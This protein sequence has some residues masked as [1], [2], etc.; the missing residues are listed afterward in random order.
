MR[1][2]LIVAVARNGVIG[3]DGALPWRIRDD[4]AW[5]RKTT[6]GKPL[7]MGRKTFTSIGKPL[8][9]RDSLVMTRDPAFIR[10][11]IYLARSMRGAIRLGEAC[12]RSR[13][14]DE[15]CVIGG[16]EI[17]AQALGRAERIYLTR[18]DAAPPGDARFPELDARD[19][20]EKRINTCAAT[21]ENQYACE[22]FILDRR[23]F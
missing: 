10:D 12:A 23:R 11:G 3:G 21:P 15:I 22:F 9:G 7:I 4:M 14:A 1:V 19:W 8:P 2:S 17:Y 20:R 6:M 5:F 13:D 18:V 16:G